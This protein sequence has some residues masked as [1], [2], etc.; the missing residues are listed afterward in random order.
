MRE[1]A[2]RVGW[3]PSEARSD[4]DAVIGYMGTL[5]DENQ[6]LAAH[7][8]RIKHQREVVALADNQSDFNRSVGRLC[9]TIDESP[10]TS[11][12]EVRAKQAE[13]SFLMGFAKGQCEYR[14]DSIANPSVFANEHANKIKNGKDGE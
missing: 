3:Q 2:C 7:V 8:G 4:Y 9:G 11:L 5:E 14:D 12:A 13:K 10:Q 6:A 1:T